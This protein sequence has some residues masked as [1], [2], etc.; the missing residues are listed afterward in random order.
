MMIR[1][2]LKIPFLYSL[3]LFL[4]PRKF[5]F[6]LRKYPKILHSPELE[7]PSSNHFEDFADRR[8]RPG[9]YYYYIYHLLRKNWGVLEGRGGDSDDYERKKII[10]KTKKVL[11]S[12]GRSKGYMGLFL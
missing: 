11:S 3:E 8:R 6:L 10:Y 12:F 4:T 5:G 7:S 9:Y 2:G 1:S